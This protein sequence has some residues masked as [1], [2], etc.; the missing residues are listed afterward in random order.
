MKLTE[1]WLSLEMLRNSRVAADRS[2]ATGVTD[3][4]VVV[5]VACGHLI[6]GQRACF[7]AG[8]A[9]RAAQRLNRLEVLDENIDIF[10]L[11]GSE[12]QSNSELQHNMRKC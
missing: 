10:H 2:V 9:S 1:E 5:A 12:S 8:N 11:D 7:I 6:H 4:A 3:F